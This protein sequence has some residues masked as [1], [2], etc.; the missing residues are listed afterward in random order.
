MNAM[1]SLKHAA[2]RWLRVL[3]VFGL[4]MMVF[5]GLLA[6]HFLSVPNSPAASEPVVGAAQTTHSSPAD[7]AVAAPSEIL[8]HEERDAAAVDAMPAE[9]AQ[10]PAMDGE[11]HCGG[12]SGSSSPQQSM[13]M[14]GCVL[15]LLVVLIMLLGPTILGRVWAAD[16]LAVRVLHLLGAVLPRPRP[17]S[18]I[19]LS[20]S[21]T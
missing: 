16:L 13:L 2:P 20:I 14:M 8:A 15:A 17:P 9:T 1:R 12:D 5:F 18:L 19:V 10:A 6:M 21:R 4:L 7:R 3:L 11:S